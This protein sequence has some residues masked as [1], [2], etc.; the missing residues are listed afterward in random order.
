MDGHWLAQAE[1]IGGMALA[2]LLG[3][4]VG[5]ERELKHRPAGFRTHMLVA[6]AAALLIG[7]GQLSVD[8]VLAGGHGPGILQVDPLRLV[9]SVIAG[10]AFI[11][12]GTIFSQGRQGGQTV[13]GITTAASLLVVATIGVAAGLHYY[14][15][16][17]AATFLAL[18]VLFVLSAW[19]R[20][21]QGRQDG[22]GDAMGVR[23]P[24][25]GNAS[26]VKAAAAGAGVGEVRDVHGLAGDRRAVVPGSARD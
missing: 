18:F 14:L 24:A 10:V 26:G 4:M 13:A 17:V 25:G 7:I 15:V 2:M 11:G 9:E 23:P 22:D 12:A 3:G 1:V 20:R 19:E 21:Q 16:A 8:R 6:G 5:Y